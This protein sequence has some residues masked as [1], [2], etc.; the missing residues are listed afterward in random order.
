MNEQV[1]KR[2]KLTNKPVI[3]TSMIA[4]LSIL[5]MPL[6]EIRPPRYRLRED[7]GDL[8]ELKQ[9][10]R[11]H[12]LLQPIVVRKPNPSALNYEVVAGHRRYIAA[13][14]LGWKE[15]SVSVAQLTDKDAFIIA[16]TENVQ[17]KTMTVPEEAEAYRK[18]VEEYG[19]GSVNELAALIKRAPS[20][21]SETISLLNLDHDIFA[22]VRSDSGGEGNLSRSHAEL[23]S[24]FDNEKQTELADF[25]TEKGLNVEQTRKATNLVKHGWAVD[26]AVQRV[27]EYPDLPIPKDTDRFDPQEDARETMS[28]IIGQ[29]LSGMDAQ[30]ERLPD[31]EE[32]KAW[33]EKVRF[34]IH[35]AKSEIFHIRKLYHPVKDEWSS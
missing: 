19:W 8:E 6:A 14:E 10:M 25:I 32:K 12:G 21:V 9:S 13:I 26:S 28:I 31:G 29:A 20:Y 17:R 16:L 33:I 35:E 15:I 24:S 18:F 1:E 23:L 11:Q 34:P 2:Q 5:A 3:G 22:R 30:L 7:L 27:L 4:Q